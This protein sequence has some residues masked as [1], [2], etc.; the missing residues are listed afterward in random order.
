MRP[1][2][3]DSLVNYTVT[4]PISEW[5]KL[6]GILVGQLAAIIILVWKVAWGIMTRI[7]AVELKVDQVI[8]SQINDVTRRVSRL[9]EW[10]DE[11]RRKPRS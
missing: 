10:A 3:T 9:E 4:L 7:Q 5:M 8:A 1:D 6:V 2:A 11:S